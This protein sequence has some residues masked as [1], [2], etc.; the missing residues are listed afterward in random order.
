MN[1]SKWKSVA[2]LVG[3]SAI[4]ASLMFVGLQLKQGHEIALANQYQARA[5][6]YMEFALA[7]IEADWVIPPLRS[8]VGDEILARD[9]SAVIWHWTYF[10]NNNFQ[11]K[12]GFLT[13][14]SW[15]ALLRSHREIYEAC[16]FRFVYEWRKPSL[17]PSV[18]ALVGTWEDPCN[19]AD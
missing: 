16:D 19:K 6:A 17:R 4:V 1:S 5:E 18:V 9:I 15:R 13:D 10:D 11:Y 7:G 2:E 3:I 8:R 14:E 12:S